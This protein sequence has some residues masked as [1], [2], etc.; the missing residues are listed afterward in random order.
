MDEAGKIINI[1][2]E[3]PDDFE[4]QMMDYA[5]NYSFLPSVN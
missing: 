3:Y 4:T 2:V 5:K 1:N